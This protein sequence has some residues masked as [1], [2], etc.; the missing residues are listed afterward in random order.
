MFSLRTCFFIFVQKTNQFHSKSKASG[1]PSGRSATLEQLRLATLGRSAPR[2]VG[3][4]QRDAWPWNWEDEKRQSQGSP[5]KCFFSLVFPLLFKGFSRVFLGCKM[6]PGP[7]QSVVS[8]FFVGCL[9]M[10]DVSFGRLRIML[11]APQHPVAGCV[12][13]LL[14]LLAGLVCCGECQREEQV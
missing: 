11:M 12:L 13:E 3:F 9:A 6:K 2:F 4:G 10:K 14:R 7:S 5:T 1:D 8:H